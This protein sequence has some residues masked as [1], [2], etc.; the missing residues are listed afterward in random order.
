MRA[1]RETHLVACLLWKKHVEGAMGVGC[2][3]PDWGRN[4]IEAIDIDELIEDVHGK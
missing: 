3:C 1:S 4:L 2:N